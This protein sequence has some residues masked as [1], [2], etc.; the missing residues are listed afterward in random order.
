MCDE[1]SVNIFSAKSQLP[2]TLQRAL[3]ANSYIYQKV[4]GICPDINTISTAPTGYT[5]HS[6]SYPPCRPRRLTFI[7]NKPQSCPRCKA[8]VYTAHLFHSQGLQSLNRAFCW[9]QNLCNQRYPQ[10]CSSVCPASQ[11]AFDSQ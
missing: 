3:T 2:K 11:S 5:A 4:R 10:T 6:H 9:Y 1:Y 8:P 7:S